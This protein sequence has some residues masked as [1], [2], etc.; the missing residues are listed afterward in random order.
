[1]VVVLGEPGSG[2]STELE[3][4]AERTGGALLTIRKFLRPVGPETWSGPLFLDGLDEA[5]ASGSD[6]NS[7]LHDVVRKLVDLGRPQIRLSCRAADW[8]GELDRE[9]LTQAYA[10]EEIGL[11]ELQPLR[12]KDVEEIVQASGLGDPVVFLEQARRQGAAD[13]LGNP[14]T[15]ELMIEVARKGALP[16]TKTELFEKACLLMAG[17]ENP[18]RRRA[19]SVPPIAPE[20]ILD[21]AGILCATILIAGLSGFAGD[22]PDRSDDFPSL[23][24]IQGLP[25]EGQAALESRLFRWEDGRA[26]PLHRTIAE[27]LA[28]R[29]LRDR[30]VGGL[31]LERV[32]HLITGHDG[33]T[34]SDLRGLFAWLTSLTPLYAEALA[35]RDPA[36]VVFYG[37]LE[38]LPPGVKRAVLAGLERLADRY[39]WFFYEGQSHSFGTLADAALIPDFR[40]A[41]ANPDRP[42]Y[43][44]LAVLAILAYGRPLS[45]LKEDLRRVVY[46]KNSPQG[47]RELALKA[48]VHVTSNKS[49]LLAVLEDLQKGA[50]LDEEDSMRAHLLESL[51]PEVVKPRDLAVYLTVPKDLS[52]RRDYYRFVRKTL[53]SKTTDQALPEV[54]DALSD[55]TIWSSQRKGWPRSA[56]PELASTLLLRGLESHGNFAP[57]ARLWSW[58]RIGRDRG[59][60]AIL[61]KE[62]QAVVRAWFDA[63]PQRVLE[64]YQWWVLEGSFAERNFFSGFWSALCHPV[65]PPD[66]WRWQISTAAVLGRGE[67]AD[68]MLQ[69]VVT[70][71]YNGAE[72]PTLDELF[73]WADQNPAFR[74][75]LESLL[76][77]KLPSALRDP[78]GEERERIEAEEEAAERAENRAYLE[79]RIE[80]V[81]VGQEKRVLD[82]L[83]SRFLDLANDR[84]GNIGGLRAIREE[85]GEDIARAAEEG[86][87]A[88]LE[89]PDWASPEEIGEQIARREDFLGGHALL[90]GVLLAE[91]REALPTLVESAGLRAA[92]AFEFV[93]VIYEPSRWYQSVIQKE[94]TAAAEVVESAWQPLLKTQPKEVQHL[95]Q[96]DGESGLSLIAHQIG[97]RLLADHS[98]AQRELLEQLMRA[99][100]VGSSRADLAVLIERE[101]AQ[102]NLTEEQYALWLALG[103]LVTPEACISRAGRYLKGEGSVERAYILVGSLKYFNG[104]GSHSVSNAPS[105][106]LADMFKL[107]GVVLPPPS[108]RESRINQFDRSQFVAS[109]A[110]ELGNRLDEEA[111]ARL[112]TLRDDSELSVW[113]ERLSEIAE[114]QLRKVR[115]SRYSRPSL[116]D[117]LKILTG[118]EPT[119]TGDLHA[120]VCDHLRTLIDEIEHGSGSGYRTYWNVWGR[121][122]PLQTP[123]VE[124]DARHRLAELLNERLKPRGITAESEA[125][126]SGGNRGDLKVIYKL[127]RVPI[128][129]KRH[130]NAEVWTAPRKQLKEKYT[131][132]PASE[133]YGI[134]LVFWFGEDKG[135]RLLAIP[136]GV[137]RPKT[138]AEM[139]SALRQI[140]CG[141]EW[142]RIEFF[143]IDCTGAAQAR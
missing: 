8:F 82:F 86:F 56:W 9:D 97:L 114:Q 134:Y 136:T 55:C 96:M 135:R 67:R 110:S 141:E 58:L 62:D 43:F 24:D 65:E 133:G 112:G 32:L 89:R 17:E 48:L 118:G 121:G 103:L 23:D 139:Q 85:F 107:L 74:E 124:N 84:S 106:A 130:Y 88:A 116:E 77:K 140:Y 87:L 3:R 75:P 40:A 61:K 73:E 113:K 59:V 129:V 70:R 15:L 16:A 81:R 143:C 126:Y 49:E 95:F 26:R 29:V 98:Q 6:R 99:A 20:K 127:M 101:V 83:A 132:D 123:V 128:E 57:P 18:R 93:E 66:L 10:T 63:R 21:A 27:F 39:P 100:L 119:S 4:E 72:T 105:D 12:D 37:D 1:V 80:V 38:P 60:L 7:V 50:V 104:I 79:E 108:L 92:L 122:D 30:I 13:W 137:T 25:E 102:Q 42:R 14:Q 142:S 35:R 41:L 47:I 109:L 34:V 22:R 2:K 90:A 51:Y 33:G 5:R 91:E 115:E 44:R 120:I 28:S 31:P 64:L 111:V 45:E 53:A 36:A 46:D 11:V 138:A 71:L 69:S 78:F 131:I 76:Y 54:L 94:P 125:H 117:V 19:R 52:S 68:A